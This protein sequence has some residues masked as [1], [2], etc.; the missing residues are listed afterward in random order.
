[1]NGDPLLHLINTGYS[2][3]SLFRALAVVASNIIDTDTAVQTLV[4]LTVVDVGLTE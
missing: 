2:F 1:M 4:I 3:N